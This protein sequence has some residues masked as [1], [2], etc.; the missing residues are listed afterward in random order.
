[1]VVFFNTY[2]PVVSLF[3]KILP[4]LN[5]KNIKAKAFISSEKYR[6]NRESV[7]DEHYIYSSNLWIGTKIKAFALI[8]YMFDASI[9]IIKAKPKYC[10][11]LTQPPMF[12]A[13]ASLICRV[14][15]IKYSVHVMDMYPEILFKR[16]LLKERSLTGKILL[17]LSLSAYK[18]SEKILTISSCMHSTLVYKG[19]K[20][21]KIDIIRNWAHNEKHDVSINENKFINKYHLHSKNIV[22]YSG[23]MGV[24]HR[25]NTILD[26]AKKLNSIRDDILFVFV[27]SGD[28]K[29]YIYNYV[30]KNNLDN[31]SFF[32]FQED[33]LLQHVLSAATL[34]YFSL[35]KAYTGN[36]L[37]SKFYGMLAS[38]RPIVFEGHK[39]CEIAHV[40]TKYSC[41]KHIE[42]GDS[43][44]L[45]NSIVELSENNK[46]S[47]ELGLNG[48]EY[49][50]KNILS[51]IQVEKYLELIKS[52]I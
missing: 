5:S 16:G 13:I 6:E 48:Y 22:L 15:K 42:Q 40:L 26:V 38:K 8:K 36:L 39:D 7:N 46:Y 28:K 10:I 32:P 11:F 31:V 34:H 14:K 25:F 19:I 17:A 12:Y 21:E 43:E 44:S 29:K 47:I 9:F 41:G 24:A 1:M 4:A 2:R 35:E 23:N 52:A 3:E 50:K 51:D 18:H 20:K 30:I 49:Y 37:P 33:S 27:G 45:M